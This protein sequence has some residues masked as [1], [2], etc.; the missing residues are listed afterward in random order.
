MK[1]AVV[2]SS[3]TGNTRKVAEAIKGALPDGTDLID[4]KD[5]K[6]AWDYDFLFVGFWVDKGTADGEARRVMGQI[7]NRD[8]A[9]F[10]TLGA[11]PDSDHARQS[12]VGGACCFGKNTKVVASF[13]CQ[14]AIDPKLIEMFRK[15]PVGSPHSSNEESEERWAAA[16][17]R[18]DG[19]DLKKAADFARNTLEIRER[20]APFKEKMNEAIKAQ[21]ANETGMPA[22]AAAKFGV[23]ELEVYKNLPEDSVVFADMSHFHRIWEEMTTWE[24]VLFFTANSGMVMEVPGKLS[25]G[26]ERQGFFNLFDRDAPVHGHIMVNN[27]DSIAFVSHPFMGRESHNVTFFSKDGSVAFSLYLGRNEKREIIPEVREAFL[28]LKGSF[29]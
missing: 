26:K 9:I 7:C 13:I 10:A 21:L 12:L 24:E 19:K 14:G 25:S 18:P 15:N 5:F 2:Y 28:K 29:S 4:A 11:Y 6:G 8:V 17:G 16:A 22:L 20:M 1:I 27:L 3:K 23:S